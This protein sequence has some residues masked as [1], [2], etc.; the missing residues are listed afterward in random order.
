[1]KRLRTLAFLSA[2]MLI[3]G[4]A[5]AATATAQHGTCFAVHATATGQN[6]GH[7][8]T[9]STI[10]HDG[11]FNGTTIGQLQITGG[12]PPVLTVIGTG[13]LTTDHGTLTVSTAGTVN[14]ATGAINVTGQVVGGT[15]VFAHATGTLTFAGVVD[16]TT[17]V[18]TNMI[19]GTVCLAHE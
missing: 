1:M 7:G 15:G 9:T 13:V 6:L 18:F 2:A 12:T 8:R 5:Q 17:N 14:Q 19:S 10:T 3:V 4:G 11:M 16:L